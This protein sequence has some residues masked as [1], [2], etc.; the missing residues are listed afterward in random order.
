MVAIQLSGPYGTVSILNIYNS[1]HHDLTLHIADVTIH[2]L[3]NDPTDNNPQ[4]DHDANY[5]TWAGDFN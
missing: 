1:Q 3:L 5:L 2:E 4:H